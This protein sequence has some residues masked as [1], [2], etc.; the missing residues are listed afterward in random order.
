MAAGKEEEEERQ[1]S[2]DPDARLPSLVR[3]RRRRPLQ[4]QRKINKGEVK[5]EKGKKRKGRRRRN[6]RQRGDVSD[7]VSG[8]GQGALVTDSVKGHYSRKAREKE[9]VTEFFSEACLR[10][11]VL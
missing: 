5:K 3:L 9:R 7:L 4:E 1:S 6:G 10:E 2:R 8:Q 11:E